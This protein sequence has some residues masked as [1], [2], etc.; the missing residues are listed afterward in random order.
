MSVSV[1][2][3]TTGTNPAALANAVRAALHS[4]ARTGDGAEVLVAV[5]GRDRIPELDGL[6]VPAAARLRVF[7]DP[8]RNVARARNVVL[9][10]ARN[11]TILFTDDD[12]VVPDEW[13]TQLSA[14]LHEPGTAVACAR[15]RTRVNGAVTAYADY[16]RIFDATPVGS[17]EV[18]MMVTA[19]CGLRR[20]LIPSNIR[21]C[22]DLHWS[23]E[24]SDFGLA[25]RAAGFRIRW[26][27]DPTPLAHG[28]SE[29]ISEI[30]DRFMRYG[31]SG[32]VLLLRR[33]HDRAA[34]PGAHDW[35]RSLTREDFSTYRRF[36]ELVDPA[37]RRT[38]VVYDY[39]MHASTIVGY[40][41]RLGEL[42]D[43]RLVEID[44]DGLARAWR[45]INERVLAQ[46][47]GIDWRALDIDYRR[48]PDALDEPQPLLADVRA[49]LRRCAPP[50]TDQP[51][52][53]ALVVLER[54]LAD[55][56]TDYLARMEQVRAIWRG[57]GEG[58]GPGAGE[59]LTSE[60]LDYRLRAAGFSFK[61]A[62]AVVEYTMMLDR[63]QAAERAKRAGRSR[64]GPRS[65]FA[66]A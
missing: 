15:V 43:C 56:V 59:P 2:I 4:A 39:L 11:D 16:Q 22:E 1:G 41:E 57:L 37:V 14:A 63:Y 34:V 48:M 24:D 17:D 51:R 33:H 10:E 21:F 47:P 12:C 29:D 49:V 61:V 55:Q 35:Y 28:L 36:G 52:G 13:C 8:R 54:G 38:F 5:N 50:P 23:G 30:T 9:A 45:D 6:P 27:A 20:D 46:A 66:T 60:L 44:R 40:L 31:A 32:A 3:A 19:N 58:A 18:E 65:P 64:R 26:L 25:L 62:C 42:L 53:D 7:D